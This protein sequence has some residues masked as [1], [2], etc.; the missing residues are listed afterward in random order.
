MLFSL[1]RIVWLPAALAVALPVLASAD[2]AGNARAAE[3]PDARVQ[4][5]VD[6]ASGPVRVRRSDTRGGLDTLRAAPGGDLA[7]GDDA[8][9][10]P[11]HR[12]RNAL[13]RD[14][15]LFR[16]RD[17]GES[18]RLA[19]R[20]QDS[21][22]YTHL[23]YTQ[24]HRGI[25][26]WGARL[27]ASVDAR[28]RLTTISAGTLDTDDVPIEP[29]V[30][31]GDAASRAVDAVRVSR[32]RT[33]NPETLSAQPARLVIHDPGLAT[34]RP[35]QATLAW[36]V[37]VTGPATRELVFVDA[38]GGR[39]IDRIDDIHSELHRRVY[40]GGFGDAFEVWREGDAVPFGQTDID[41]LIDYAGETYNLFATLTGGAFLS[42]DG[43]G[44]PMHGVLNPPGFSCPNAS[45]NGEYSRYCRGYTVDDVV[46][47]EYTHG[48][49]DGTH[50]LIYR[51][52]SGALNEAYSDILGEVV[53]ILNA[54]GLDEPD[55][56]RTASDCSEFGGHLPPVTV[57]SPDNLAGIY[58]AGTASFNPA[59][60]RAT[61]AVATA[62]D[63]TAPETDGC[64]PL[65]NGDDV[66]GHIVVVENHGRCAGIVQARNA[67]AAGAAGVLV[68]NTFSDIYYN[69]A[70]LDPAIDIPTAVIGRSAGRAIAD[71]TPPAMVEIAFR[72]VKDPSLRWLHREGFQ[73]F[74]GAGGPNRDMWLPACFGDPGRVGDALYHCA[75][76]DSGGV[77]HNSGIVNRLFALL[78][79]GGDAQGLPIDAIGLTR[80]THLYWRA[81]AHYQRPDTDFA[82]HADALEASCADLA[83]HGGPLY[84]LS[85]DTDEPALSTQSIDASHCAALT[86]AI[87]AVELRDP[88]PCDFRPLLDPDVPALC[89]DP[90]LSVPGLAFDF[91][92][93]LGA[94]QV[95][96]RDLAD[97]DTFD[98]DDWAVVDDLPHARAGAAAFAPNPII[99]N[100]GN[101]TEAGVLF[102]ESP[103]FVPPPAD[104]SPWLEF[105]HLPATESDY[106]GGNLKIRVND[107]PWTLVPDSAFRHNGYTSAL[108]ISDNPM[109]GEPAWHGSDDN[110][111][112]SDWGTSQ[113][114]LDVPLEP[115][116]RYRLRFELGSD[117]CNGLVGWYVDDVELSSCPARP[118]ADADGI[119]DAAD[120]CRLAANAAQRDSDGDGY[121]NRCD[122]DLNN[123]GTVTFADLAALRAAW[124]SDDA[125]ADLDGNG[126]VDDA[127]LDILRTLF[128]GPPGPGAGEN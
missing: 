12:V 48:Y 45:W 107:G 68:V 115:G 99:G 118:D 33:G 54:D 120:N 1:P 69:L 124:G 111:L 19:T 53:D 87:D 80:A 66:A 11:D 72:E 32:A 74:S 109:G 121:G 106:D 42:W 75:R 5:F 47:H 46:A 24:S 3:T 98:A 7:G 2:D 86:A 112:T 57:L 67:H 77:H 114:E 9:G 95:G 17:A 63:D 58:A 50:D 126:V 119:P 43:V 81:M 4:R 73:D 44:A 90:T 55:L 40:D 34:P 59:G 78:V 76:S 91:E 88:P 110:R 18:L 21:L 100:C 71:A 15:S 20:R 102:L 70:G 127:D 14:P 85:V 94:W 26:V 64:Q 97:A 8:H 52:Q 38:I 49:T 6:A 122:P 39:I 13:A 92:E 79:D 60:A 61:A 103:E 56:P 117:G 25:E 108:R 16:L 28:G 123:D 96:R 93:G 125:D 51:W 41:R 105:E 116:D 27:K 65:V 62:R 10:D 23:T 29:R 35:G 37:T 83:A 30:S 89:G 82:G 31:A 22:G 101:D 128:L 113:V 36:L 104:R 84:A